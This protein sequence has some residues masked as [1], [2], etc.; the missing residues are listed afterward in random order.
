MTI[1]IPHGTQPVPLDDILAQLLDAHKRGELRVT[2]IKQYRQPVDAYTVEFEVVPLLA[3]SSANWPKAISPSSGPTG[4][5]GP[6]GATGTNAQTDDD[7]DTGIKNLGVSKHLITGF[8]DFDLV[9][10]HEGFILTSRNNAYW[11]P[12]KKMVAY[13]T[14]RG[15]ASEH[16]A[17]GEYCDCGIYAFS[18]PDHPDLIAQNKIWGEIAMWGEVLICETGY[19][20]EY[21]YP[22]NLFMRDTGT[23]GVRYVASELEQ[24]YGVP[25]FLVPERRGQTAAQIMQE[26]LANI[27]ILIP[28][29]D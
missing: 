7:D 13:C 23:K 22:T 18:A 27:D 6:T 29:H 16:D 8:R 9:S 10:L 1:N 2:K 12:R 20:A 19:R 15:I 26:T 24:T 3:G 4:H 25:V 17:P 14:K 5:I 11:R 21:A 28:D